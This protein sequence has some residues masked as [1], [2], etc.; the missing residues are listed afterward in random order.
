[1]DGQGL[2]F[3]C[4]RFASP[5]MP[6][7]FKQLI[8]TINFRCLFFEN[9]YKYVLPVLLHLKLYWIILLFLSMS[10]YIGANCILLFLLFCKF[11]N[12]RLFFRLHSTYN[13][14]VLDCKYILPPAVVFRMFSVDSDGYSADTSD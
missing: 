7:L 14:S 13:L 12:V 6:T 5:L 1:M 11:N 4:L 10:V 2:F 3:K 8:K 9:V